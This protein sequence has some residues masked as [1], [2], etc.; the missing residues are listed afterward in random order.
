M[1]E[2]ARKIVRVCAGIKEGEN[3]LIVTDPERLG[4]AS[5]LAAAARGEGTEP[6]TV[7]MK[8]NQWDGQEPHPLAAKLMHAPEVDV[9]F[10]PVTRSISHSRAVHEALRLG[11]RVLSLPKFQE[12]QLWRGGI[13]ADFDAQKVQCDRMAEAFSNAETA[14]L[15]TPAGTHLRFDLRGRPGNSHPCIARNPGEFTALINIEANV[16]PNETAT[17]GRLV[18]DGSIPNF[19]IGTIGTPIEMEVR[20]GRIVSIRGGRE[21]H[22]L[23]RILESLGDDAVYTIAQLA[24]GLNPECHGFNGWFSNDHGVYGS[25]HIGIGTSENLG[26]T[27]RAPVH[28][29]VMMSSP[30]LLL[31]GKPVVQDGQVLI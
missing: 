3:V 2:G 16:A 24:V 6:L 8:P 29:D 25:A 18:V 30:T 5:A 13:H 9:I 31:D 17:E 19:D 10:M 4:V 11:K 22:T 21:A 14:E 7:V 15:T 28:F 26:G 1:M 23:R 20:E 27:S 12:E